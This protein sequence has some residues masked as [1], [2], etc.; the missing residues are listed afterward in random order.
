MAKQKEKAENERR[1]QGLAKAAEKGER[2]KKRKA[3]DAS[4]N[5]TDRVRAGTE[6]TEDGHRTWPTKRERRRICDQSR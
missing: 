1:G 5:R 2:E 3:M 4:R 6:R